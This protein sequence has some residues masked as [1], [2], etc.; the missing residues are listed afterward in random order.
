MD[1]ETE[2]AAA[3]DEDGLV[4]L[5]VLVAGGFGAGK[6]TLVQVLSEIPPLLTEQAMTTAS[7]GVDDSSVV[8]DKR[9]TT[10]AM[11]FG[12]ITVD[13][14][15]IPLKV[16]VAGGFGAGKTTLVQALSEI[17]PLLTEQAMT[18]ASI[19]VDDSAA[20]PDKRTTTVAMD[21][22]RITV[23]S[24]LILYLFGTPGQT[25][26]W[27][28]WDELARGGVGAVVLVDLRRIDDCF[29]AI[30]YFESRR[31]PFVVGV[32]G[33]PG[34]DAHDVADV[35]DA[36]AL[37]ADVPVVR[38]DARDMYG[39][40]VVPNLQPI[41]AT[42]THPG[43]LF[44]PIGFGPIAPT[45]PQRLSRLGRHPV[46]SV[47]DLTSR[48]MPEGID[49]LF[50][51][52]APQDQYVQALRDNER[53][54]LENLHPK[55]PRLVTSLPGIRPR[56]FV[57]G[58][59]SGPQA[60]AMR[61]DT[62]AFDTDQAVCTLT[63]RGQ[64][65]L[66]HP[67]EAV[68]VLI[69]MEQGAQALTWAE[70]ERAAKGRR[71]SGAYNAAPPSNAAPAVKIALDAV[72]TLV[73]PMDLEGHAGSTLPFMSVAHASAGDERAAPRSGGGLPFVAHAPGA[74]PQAAPPGAPLSPS[75]PVP[76]IASPA[77]VAPVLPVA[78]PSA[79][80]PIPPGGPAAV[81]SA[82]SPPPLFIAES[83][84]RL[85]AAPPDVAIKSP[86][87]SGPPR[88]DDRSSP[89]PSPAA[90]A[91]SAGEPEGPGVVRMSNAAAAK[92]E[93]R[94]PRPDGVAAEPPGGP[95][96]AAARPTAARGTDP[97][98]ALSLI[99]FDP[100]HV[101]RLRKHKPFREILSKAESQPPDVELDGAPVGDLPVEVEDRR[102][103]FEILTNASSI[104][105]PGVTEALDR[106]IREDGKVVPPLVLCA[107]ELF[108]PFDE[109]EELKATVATVTP[110]SSGD[111]NL[112]SSLQIAKEFLALPNLASA[113]AVA[114]GLMKRIYDAFGQGK[115][116]VTS[117]YIEAQVE[118]ALLEQR[119]YQRRKVL[120][121][122]HL[123]GLLVAVGGRDPIPTYLP[124]SVSEE[125]PMY[126]RFRVRLIAE[127]R[128]GEDQYESHP[129]A[130]KVLALGRVIERA[131]R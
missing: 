81:P 101:R 73:G 28:M 55:H 18:T 66:E 42:L 103:V 114:E 1:A 80:A 12:R 88:T 117:D 36:L 79:V 46:P 78:S 53:I 31:L 33:F 20:V 112:K 60:L 122:K 106:S 34:T 86:W 40:T 97:R 120:G 71:E 102:D 113:P 15:L 129:A 98:D 6:T 57:E 74:L 39:N 2:G 94:G 93:W 105:A 61:A 62:L 24:A 5:K 8:P 54:L 30:D 10:V 26:F 123:R 50:F 128:L 37:P 14:A 69:A 121:G 16:L 99:W 96:A 63:W 58:R 109:V 44:D 90:A 84:A 87:A 65:P 17:P 92:S 13:A 131:R 77:P 41:G 11:D 21:F 68:R 119:Y 111:E 83:A 29:P 32:N 126:A 108:M 67:Q 3:G 64:L 4:P 127:V 91:I 43:D 82:P 52:T 100:Q 45:W 7:V 70:V 22:G 89:A 115:R 9:T 47:Q 19:G 76:P 48:P 75:A 59:S 104:D 116:A 27:F 118:R 56:A 72:S 110:L 107:G 51:N 25:R 95:N 85:A 35:R 125:L 23:D 124:E 49:L 38:L 130:L